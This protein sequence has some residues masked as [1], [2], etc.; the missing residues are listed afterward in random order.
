VSSINLRAILYW[1]WEQDLIDTLPP[2]P[3]PRNQRD[4]ASGVFLT[5]LF[6]KSVLKRSYS[7]EGRA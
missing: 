7:N 5:D 6:L 4:V 2:F 1:V 3:A